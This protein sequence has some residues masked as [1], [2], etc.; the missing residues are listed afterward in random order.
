MIDSSLQIA[1]MALKSGDT[2]QAYLLLSQI[3]TEQ[4]RNISAWLWLSGAVDND[5]ERRRCL[6]RVLE[7]DPQNTAAQRGL[8]QLLQANASNAALTPL[9]APPHTIQRATS[10]LPALPSSAVHAAHQKQPGTLS[11]TETN[12]PVSSASSPES[13]QPPHASAPSTGRRKPV[14][15]NRA[16]MWLGITAGTVLAF[17]AICIIGISVLTLLRKRADEPISAVTPPPANWKKFEGVNAALWLPAS[18]VGGDLAMNKAAV[19]EEIRSLG[20]EYQ[21]I[22]QTAEQ[23]SSVDMWMADGYAEAGYSINVNV[24]KEYVS[25]EVTLDQYV[26]QMVADDTNQLRLISREVTPRGQHMQARLVLEMHN[27]S[28]VARVVTYV[29]R[30]GRTCWIISFGTSAENYSRALSISEQSIRTF[31]VMSRVQ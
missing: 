12:P 30:N 22:A 27:S 18:F 23:T 5:V 26:D 9:S 13:R 4:P 25:A 3:V 11:S 6:E 20:P 1:I 15:R 16:K 31:A 24:A 8:G 28:H 21:H 7:L 14:R 10:L 29:I 17:C 2:A 19:V